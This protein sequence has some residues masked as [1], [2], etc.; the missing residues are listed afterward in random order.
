IPG[1]AGAGVQLEALASRYAGRP[2]GSVRV[3]GFVDRP[4]WLSAHL[5]LRPGV[6]LGYRW[7]SLDPA[8]FSAGAGGLLVHPRVYQ[9]YVEDHPFVLRPQVELRAYPFQDLALSVETSLVPNSNF[10]GVDHFD[11]DLG[12]D[13]IGRMPRPWLPTWGMGYQSSLR[14]ADAD[15]SRS[16]VRHSIDAS[17]GAAVW[18]QDAVLVAFGLGDRVYVTPG[19]ATAPVRNVFELWVRI[20]GAFGRRF[21]DFGPRE[22]W[23]REP[24]AP[25]AWGDSERQ[26]GSTMTRGR[27]GSTGSGSGGASPTESQWRDAGD[28]LGD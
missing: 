6:D 8:R 10:V 18:A 25:R 23:F 7:Q 4:V 20:N 13:G 27:G 3:E 28:G 11:V 2:E 24:W 22:Q 5:Q 14:F 15:R 21:R 1:G 9:D 12:L 19:A 16:F 17:L 26:A